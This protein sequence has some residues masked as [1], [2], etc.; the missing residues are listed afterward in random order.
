[1]IKIKRVYEPSRPPDGYRILIDRLW[2]RGLSKA[3]ASI[4]EWRKDLAPSDR[5]RK[6]FNHEPKKWDEFR[7][8]YHEELRPKAEELREL[9][10]KKRPGTI[11]ILYGARDKEH[12]NAVALKELLEELR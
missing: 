11:T 6:W 8:R 12:N 3:K 2:P 9:A 10:R 1:M 4:D 7:R 5:L